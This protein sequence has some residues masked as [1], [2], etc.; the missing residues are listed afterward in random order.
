MVYSDMV[1]SAYAV[2]KA[3]VTYTLYNE[4]SLYVVYTVHIDYHMYIVDNVYIVCIPRNVLNAY[5]AQNVHDVP[6]IL[7][8][9]GQL[10]DCLFMLLTDFRQLVTRLDLT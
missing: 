10:L 4:Y 5:N 3:Y 6:G 2:H 9:R 8:G 7:R 1:Y